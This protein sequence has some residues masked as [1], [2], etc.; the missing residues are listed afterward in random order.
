MRAIAKAVGTIVKGMAPGGV[1]D[2]PGPLIKA[3]TEYAKLIEPWANS[4]SNLML[5]DVARRDRAMWRQN[6][7]EM[8]TAIA[9]E[10]EKAP[11]GEILRKLQAEQVELIK[12]LPLKAAQRVHDLSVAA[13]TDSVRASTIA[14]Q[15]LET[16]SVTESRAR[17]IAR[18]EVSR[19]SSN[20]LQARSTWAGS[21]GYVW[22]TSGDDDVRDSHKAMEGVYVRWSQPPT[23]DGMK[24]HAGTLPNCRCFAEPVFPDD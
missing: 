14:K 1:I 23:L 21:D 22:R 3:L 2:N 6:S 17:L 20:L 8:A 9:R 16:S 24:G 13:I 15:I 10:V 11:T 18:T 7:K 4:V 12:S 19:A 5:A